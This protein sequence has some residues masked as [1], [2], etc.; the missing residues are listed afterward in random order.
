M[1][2]Q[3]YNDN[4]SKTRLLQV[5]FSIQQKLRLEAQAEAHGFKSVSDYIRF[6]VLNPSFDVKLNKI[7]AIVEKNNGEGKISKN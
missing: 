1:Q 6:L 3:A 7:L 2:S 4:T 5:R